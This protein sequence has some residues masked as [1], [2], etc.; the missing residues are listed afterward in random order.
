[1]IRFSSAVAGSASQGVTIR[2]AAACR[3][4]VLRFTRVLCGREKSC[5]S[6]CPD[7]R[8]QPPHNSDQCYSPPAAA[9]QVLI[10]LLDARHKRHE[11]F[12]PYAPCFS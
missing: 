4:S 12:H 5:F 3:N 2:Q 7:P 10:V 11:R 8:R 9:D 6:D 1:M